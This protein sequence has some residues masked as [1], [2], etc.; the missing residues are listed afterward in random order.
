VLALVVLPVRLAQA[1]DL[2]SPGGWETQV[3][4]E[5]QHVAVDGSVVVTSLGNGSANL[6]TTFAPFGDINAS[7]FRLRVT[8]SDSWY[9]FVANAKPQTF[10]SGNTLEAGLQAGYQIAMGRLSFIGLVGPT[11]AESLSN[12]M[13]SERWGAKTDISVFALPSDLTMFYGSVS[14]STIEDAVQLQAKFGLKLAGDFYI[15]PEANF[16]WRNAVPSYDNVAVMRIGGHVSA[17]ALG[18]VQMGVSAGW[19][20]QEGLGTGY[21][22]GVNFYWS[23]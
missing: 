6:N 17:M 4:P 21:Y 12:G 2:P 1:L 7:G 8:G 18:P 9:R 5:P 14:Y 3:N 15:G 11:F 19:A 16:S 10:G 20:Q 22:G 23:F 13:N